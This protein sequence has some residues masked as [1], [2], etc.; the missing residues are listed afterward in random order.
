MLYGKE[1][2]ELFERELEGVVNPLGFKIVEALIIPGKETVK[3]R[4]TIYSKNGVKVKDCV[5]VSKAI[6]SGYDLESAFGENYFLEV[7]SPGINRK[8]KRLKE[9]HIF[10]GKPVKLF[11]KDKINGKN[12]FTGKIKK[13]ENNKI[14]ISTDENAELSFDIF[15]ISKGKI[16]E[17][18]KF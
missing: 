18:I 2:R 6:E 16:N 12:C 15:E 10:T 1:E 5:S 9:Y 7:S 11:L 13:V 4:I 3:L 14:F 8:L 17:K